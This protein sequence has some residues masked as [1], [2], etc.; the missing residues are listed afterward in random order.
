[1]G[2]DPQLPSDRGVRLR[3]AIALETETE[4]DHR[5]LGLAQL[6]DDPANVLLLKAHS[7][8][9]PRLRIRTEELADSCLCIVADRPVEARDHPRDGGQLRYLRDSQAGCVGELL[10]RGLVT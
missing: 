7:D 10:E 2:L 6:V 5:T 1:M 3:L 9:F 8:L 4:P